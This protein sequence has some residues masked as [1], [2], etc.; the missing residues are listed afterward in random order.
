MR[1]G[2]GGLEIARAANRARTLAKPDESVLVL[3][4]DV[5]LAALIGRPRPP[6][7][8]AIVFVDQYAPRLA[9]DDIARLDEKLPKVIIIHP[10]RVTSWQ[11]FFRIWSGKSGA[12]TVIQHVLIGLLPKHY[13]KDSSYG[14]TFLFQPAALDL[15][16]RQDDGAAGGD[17]PEIPT[18]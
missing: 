11:R 1:V 8:G 9:L 18:E 6:L 13:K 2:A 3:P 14:T 10:R 17:A 16:V 12:E 5:E 15:Y 7:L 4:E